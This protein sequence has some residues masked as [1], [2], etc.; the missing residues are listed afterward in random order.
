MALERKRS[1]KRS[2]S[3]YSGKKR[4][5]VNKCKTCCRKFTAFMFSHV[6]LC[7]LV[8]GYTIMGAFAFRALEAPYE[9]EKA[10]EVTDMRQKTVRRLW[11]ITYDLNVLYKDNWTHLVAA[12]IKRFQSDLIAAVKDGYD[13]KELGAVQQWSF[14][15]AF[16]YSLTVITTIG[17]GNIAPRTNWGKLVTIVYAIVGIPLMLLYLT[18]IGDILAKSFRYVYG[19][20]CTCKPSDPYRRGRNVENYRVQHVVAH[21][22][23][24]RQNALEPGVQD[25]L[26]VHP[27]DEVRIEAIPNELHEDLDYQKPRVS[28]PITLCLV[29][30]VSYISGG[31]V[32]FS[33]W[34]GWGFLDG[35]YFCFVTL[36]TIGFGDLVPGDSVVSDRGSQE[37]LVI[38]SLYLLIGM[39][40]IAMCFNLMQEEVI[41]KVR[42]CGRRVGIIKDTDDDDDLA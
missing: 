21:N 24:G 17:Y 32:I 33:L 39:A 1:T 14:S 8:V 36:S 35:S 13:G 15:G 22:S 29:I 12:E 28:V 27:E 42:N 11:D 10:G 26:H 34:E 20:M 41:N 37:K 9:E 6:G 23:P 18:N 30:M 2:G 4:P 40:L 5:P 31:A 16:L 19:R 25:K 7:G 3:R 38:C